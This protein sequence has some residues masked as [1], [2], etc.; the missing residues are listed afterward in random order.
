M[1]DHARQ[2]LHNEETNLQASQFATAVQGIIAEVQ[3]RIIGKDDIIK[4]IVACYVA[5]G[6]VLLE[7]RPGV[8]KSTL[9]K[10]FAAALGLSFKRIQM[11][12]DLLPVDVVGGNL[13][14]DGPLGTFAF[15]AGPIFAPI[16]FVDELNRASARTQSALLEAM[17]ER[18]VTCDGVSHPLPQPFFV[19]ATQNPQD[20][21]GTSPL[22]DSQLDR[23]LVKLTLG[24][25]SRESERLLLQGRAS[26]LGALAQRHATLVESMPPQTA[27]PPNP[28]IAPGVIIW[29]L[30]SYL[31][32]QVQVAGAVVEYILDLITFTREQCGLGLS[33]RASLGLLQLCK[34][35]ALLDGR[36]FVVPDDVK[37]VFPH[38][39]RHR[40]QPNA[41]AH[42]LPWEDRQDLGRWV[43]RQVP[44]RL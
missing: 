4:T 36:L 41:V 10:A 20:H 16:V 40:V 43:L 38:V 21:A 27:A 42:D 37:A 26:G 9:S 14:A 7:D 22:P 3:R 5:G 12:A 24:L 6:H 34:A 2:K 18:N 29:E 8:G 19:I 15:R 44:V 17:E 32:P 25:P 35:Q 13:P 11:T 1:A 30:A 31:L 33:P 39:A 23:F 28:A